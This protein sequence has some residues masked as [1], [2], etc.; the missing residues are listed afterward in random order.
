M[1]SRR[2]NAPIVLCLKLIWKKFPILHHSSAHTA[3]GWAQLNHQQ[4]NLNLFFI[5]IKF[6]IYFNL[7]NNLVKIHLEWKQKLLLS[8]IW[9]NN[10]MTI[11]WLFKTILWLF[12]FRTYHI[13]LAPDFSFHSSD[14]RDDL[15]GASRPC[16]VVHEMN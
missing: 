12:I 14:L 4:K 3:Y 7:S 5:G 1:R 6:V 10:F 2:S 13:W 16:F 9:L 8:T 15:F 11:L